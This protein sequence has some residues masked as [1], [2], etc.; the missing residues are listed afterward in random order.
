MKSLTVLEQAHMPS[1]ASLQGWSRDRTAKKSGFNLEGCP[2]PRHKHKTENDLYRSEAIL[3]ASPINTQQ[4]SDL[5]TQD[6]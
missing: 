4:G 1:S 2:Q 5:D 3:M 6:K